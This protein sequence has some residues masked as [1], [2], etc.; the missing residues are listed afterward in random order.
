MVGRKAH[1]FHV[2]FYKNL[3]QKLNMEDLFENGLVAKGEK[4]MRPAWIEI[5]LNALKKNIRNLKACVSKNA[6][7]MGV[8]KADGYGHGAIKM[9]EV[10]KQEG[11]NRFAVVMMEEGIALRRAGYTEPILILG[12]TQ[13]EDFEK[14]LENKLTPIVYKYSQAAELNKVAEKMKMKAIVH[15]F[16]LINTSPLLASCLN[17]PST[18]PIGTTPKTDGL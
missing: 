17:T 11:V 3:Y 12:H 2:R 7:F 18:Y 9:A 14:T 6:D 1:P 8:I 16:P 5:D 15:L 4:I 13:E 10:L